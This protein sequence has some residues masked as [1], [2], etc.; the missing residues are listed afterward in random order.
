MHNCTVFQKSLKEFEGQEED[1]N[2][3]ANQHPVH[4]LTVLPIL[5]IYSI[6]GR[7][8]CRRPLSKPLFCVVTVFE[9]VIWIFSCIEDFV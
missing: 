6:S 3:F 2:I 9:F 8:I 4:M 5:Y 7:F 1:D